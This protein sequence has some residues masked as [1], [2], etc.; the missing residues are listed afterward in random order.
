MGSVHSVVGGTGGTL[1]SRAGCRDAL[2]PAVSLP[3]HAQGAQS[4][5]THAN[6]TQVL[7]AMQ[8]SLEPAILVVSCS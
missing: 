1:F 3:S 8:P 5:H 6:M 2:W 4:C 7:H